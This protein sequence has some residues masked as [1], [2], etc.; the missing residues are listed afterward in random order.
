ML[1]AGDFL[2]SVRVE[3][4]ASGGIFFSSGEA[5]DQSGRQ[6]SFSLSGIMV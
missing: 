4:I 6:K 5:S 2:I 1:T 3:A